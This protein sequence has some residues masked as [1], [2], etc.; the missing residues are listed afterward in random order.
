MKDFTR[1]WIEGS[2]VAD[3]IDLSIG[4]DKI[5]APQLG[6]KFDMAFVD[7]DKRTYIETY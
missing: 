3:K 1:P 6:V 5:E 7:G 2:N 4:D